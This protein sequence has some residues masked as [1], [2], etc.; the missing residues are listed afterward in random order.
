MN[1][2]F[3]ENGEVSGYVKSGLRRSAGTASFHSPTRVSLQ[4]VLQ[5]LH[6]PF[7]HVFTFFMKHPQFKRTHNASHNL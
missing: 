1:K 5:V 4:S 2:Y 7:T 6:F 3:S